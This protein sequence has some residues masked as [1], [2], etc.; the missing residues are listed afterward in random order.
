MERADDPAVFDAVARA[1]IENDLLSADSLLPL[2]GPR[3]ERGL[4]RAA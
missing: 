2:G 3:P 1:Y 4:G